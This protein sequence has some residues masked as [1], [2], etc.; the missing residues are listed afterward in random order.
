MKTPDSLE[1][2]IAALKN[3]NPEVR[4]VAASRLE[5]TT[6]EKFGANRDSLAKKQ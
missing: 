1:V 4:K 5:E 6:G 2:L 3:K